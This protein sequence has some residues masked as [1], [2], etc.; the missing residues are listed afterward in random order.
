[1]SGLSAL[2]HQVAVEGDPCAPP[3]EHLRRD[4][5]LHQR[6]LVADARRVEDVELSLRVRRRDLVLND[7]ALGPVADDRALRGLELAPASRVPRAGRVD[8]E[9]P[10]TWRRLRATKHHAELLTTLVREDANAVVLAIHRGEPTHCLAHQSR[11][12]P[13]RRVPHLAI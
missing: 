9:R 2:P 11:L 6:T 1:P 4:S 3:I 5:Q 8:L 13:D 12:R 7:F 10:S